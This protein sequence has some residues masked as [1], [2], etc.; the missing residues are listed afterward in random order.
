MIIIKKTNV[1]HTLATGPV[2]VYYKYQTITLW[3]KPIIMFTLIFILCLARMILSK[4][5]LNLEEK[6]EIKLKNE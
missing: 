5:K 1:M 2:R 3:R 4:L 6:D